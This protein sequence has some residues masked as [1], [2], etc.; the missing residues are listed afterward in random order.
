M[1]KKATSNNNGPRVTEGSR[2]YRTTKDTSHWKPSTEAESIGSNQDLN[3]LGFLYGATVDG[4]SSDMGCN[5]GMN[6]SFDPAA[7]EA[8][9]KLRR[10]TIEQGMSTF[11]WPQKP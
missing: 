5:R 3:S 1:A 8:R 6:W 2:Q 7:H 9:H 4:G 11:S 10:H